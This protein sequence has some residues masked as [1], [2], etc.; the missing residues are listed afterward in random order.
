MKK[1]KLEIKISPT[2]DEMGIVAANDVA[3]A[4]KAVLKEKDE[5]NMIFAA[6]P[7]QNDMLL[8]LCEKTDIALLCDGGVTVVCNTDGGSSLLTRKLQGINYIGRRT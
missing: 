8:H 5:V 1:D 6:A 3:E 2:R 7:S 4:I